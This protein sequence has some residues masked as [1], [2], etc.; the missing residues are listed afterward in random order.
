MDGAACATARLEDDP[1][2]AILRLRAVHDG[3]DPRATPW[4][5]EGAARA[6]DRVRE[7]SF[8]AMESVARRFEATRLAWADDFEPAKYLACVEMHRSKL[9]AWAHEGAAPDPRAAKFARILD[10]ALFAHGTTAKP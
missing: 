5:L 6:E 2:A 7:Q 10:A 8:R 1:R 9:G 4:L 3:G